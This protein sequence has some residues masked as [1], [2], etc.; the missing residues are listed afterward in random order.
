MR[1]EKAEMKLFQPIMV[2][3]MELKNRF[4][5]PPMGTWF[6]N[7]DGTVSERLLNYYARRAQGGAGMVT[8][9]VTAVDPTQFVT[10]A[11]LRISDDSFLPGLSRLAT[12]IKTND[13]RAV[14]QLHHPG[15]QNR[16][17][18]TGFQPVAPSPLPCPLLREVPKELT[19]DEIRTLVDRFAQAAYRARE[20]GFD[21]IELHGAHGYLLCQFLSAYSNHRQDEY[22]GNISRRTR[23]S[24]EVVHAIRE[25][26]GHDYPIIFRLSAEEHIEGGLTLGETSVIARMLEEAGV[27]CLSVSAGNYGALEWMV[28]PV[29]FSSGCLVP[30]A[31]TIK[32][33]VGLPII[34]AGRITDPIRAENILQRGD[35]DL[36]A[37]GRG[38][39]ADPD[40]PRKAREQRIGEVRKCITCMS[41]QNELFRFDSPLACLINADAG[42]EGDTE[43]K[44]E[45]PRKVLV[46]GAGPA[47]LEAA[48]VSGLKGHKVTVWEQ[49][50]AIGGRWAW[51]IHGYIAEQSRI[52]KELGVKIQVG[53]QLTEEQVSVLGPGVVLYTQEATPQRL[54]GVEGDRV[55]LADEVL[56]GKKQ[57][58]GRAVVMGAGSSGCEVALHLVRRGCQVTIVEG[59]HRT[60]YGL[61]MNTGRAI[62]QKLSQSGINVLNMVKVKGF[63]EA[64]LR[65]EVDDDG[66]EE[67][68]PADW[69]VLALGC[70]P[71]PGIPDWLSSLGIEVLSI[72]YCDQPVMAYRVAQKGAAIARRL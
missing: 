10:H 21:A 40:L 55:L 69:V 9:E 29:L 46:V 14:I 62:A 5:F 25:R 51:L 33:A 47:G 36:V 7:T 24:L 23:F 50:Q 72:P 56:G 11:Q 35:A 2:G 68:V 49:A 13:G 12:A 54:P 65:Y 34:V 8:V 31:A 45:N 57:I 32:K 67:S 19:V 71:T 63:E 20:A 70:Q 59:S 38:L 64:A 52:L 39:L 66:G 42:H 41:C 3:S 44:A 18:V 22:G 15:R 61:E 60:A 6:A 26:V 53:R 28:Q 1:K 58:S 16:S 30:S 37:F 4:V 48:R 27:D 17:I 43:G